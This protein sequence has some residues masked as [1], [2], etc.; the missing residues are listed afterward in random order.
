MA[1]TDD[2]ITA[3][4]LPVARR[5]CASLV[6]A[7]T[8]AAARPSRAAAEEPPAVPEPGEDDFGPLVEI[9]RIA[10]SGN[11]RTGERLIRRALL[12]REGET[13]RSGDPRLVES[14][15]RV[16]ALGYFRRVTFGLGKGSRRGAI[17]L[18]VEVEER[19]TTTLNR[20]FLGT[21]ELT[22]VWAGLDAGDTNLFGS[23][24]AVSAAFVWAAAP[25]LPGGE[26][27]LALRLGAG[28]PSVLGSRVGVRGHFLSAD[29]SEAV[30][31]A[32]LGYRRTGGALGATFD[33][34]RLS[35]LSLDVRVESV[36]AGEEAPPAILPGD[37]VLSA[38][39]LGF[40]L[41]RRP[42]PI[43]PYDGDQLSLSVEA[44]AGDYDFVRARARYGIWRRLKGRHIGG[45]VVGAGIIFGDAPL[46]DRFFVGDLNPLLTP[47]A[48][49]LRL[50]TRE[51]PD[52]L[53]SDID[54]LSY[55]RV[56]GTFAIEYAL[57]LFRWERTVHGGDLFAQI[58]V[59]GL[60]ETDD[61]RVD[62]TFNAGLRLDTF[63]GVFELSL[64]NALG[65]IPY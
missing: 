13:L 23:G 7:V 61:V 6:I 32:A 41:D 51:S 45:V 19:G 28:D 1:A 42:D 15:Y 64:G 18:T 20:I 52:F 30:G 53:G 50:S 12:V 46:F 63:I 29:A 26:S 35:T 10:V 17:V 58:G 4:I 55:G 3:M 22:D 34:S 65:R 9:E 57:Q 60:G 49:D 27:Q 16:L 8:A 39:I 37:S 25:D 56:A 59:I 31:D 24:V 11:V 2:S 54:E 62:L 36:R 48:L 40:D 33:L 21:S 44:G 5:L 43:L 38:L 47:R 14:R